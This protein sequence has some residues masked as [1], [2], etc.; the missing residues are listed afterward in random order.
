MA[1][2][3]G[4]VRVTTQ[5]L[6]V[7]SIDEENDLI[8]VQGAV[9]GSK[10]GWVLLSDAIKKLR[11][12]DAPFPA[13]LANDMAVSG[14]A[15]SVEEAVEKELV[16]EAQAVDTAVSESPTEEPKEDKEKGSSDEG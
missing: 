5:N 16:I 8:L 7:V 14:A 6:E 10:N 11:P 13:G 3:M 9:P 15:G 2:H 4:A 12:D 1:G